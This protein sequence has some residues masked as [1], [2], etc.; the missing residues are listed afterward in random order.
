MPVTAE[1][2][3]RN[4]ERLIEKYIKSAEYS[5]IETQAAGIN[6]IAF[7]TDRIEETI[8]FYTKVVGLKLLR[9]RPLDHEPQSTMIFF[10]LGRNELLAFLCLADT[11]DKAAKG[12]GGIHHFAVTITHEQYEGFR[13]RAE[14]RGIPYNTI[15]HEILTSISALDPNG[16]EV[17][18]SVWN[19]NPDDMSQKKELE[20]AC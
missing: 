20:P 13:Q 11:K 3:E 19:M 14:A 7:V 6:H 12:V 4:R 18:L 10:D 8:D 17:E 2:A 5:D 16:I 9:I 1:E 15:A